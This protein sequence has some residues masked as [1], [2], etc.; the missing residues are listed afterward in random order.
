LTLPPAKTDMPFAYYDKLSP[1]RQA[2]YRRSDAIGP[3]DLP[4][5]L[6]V[7]EPVRTIDDGLIRGHRATVQLGSQRLIDALVKGFEVPEVDVLVLAVRPSDVEGELHGLYEPDEELPTARIS[8]WM[9]T[10]QKKQVVAFRSFVR[11]VVHE[12]LHHLDYEHFKLPETFH[13]EGFYKRE[14]SLSNALFMAAGLATPDAVGRNGGG[15]RA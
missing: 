8:V 3:L 7:A 5:G 1:D 14:S 13:T 6:A 12:F 15:R 2:I 9:R 11:T 10:A 4:A